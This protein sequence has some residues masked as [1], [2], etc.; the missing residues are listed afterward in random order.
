MALCKPALIH[1]AQACTVAKAQKP[2]FIKRFQ[3]V[4]AHWQYIPNAVEVN[5]FP[6]QVQNLNNDVKVLENHRKVAQARKGK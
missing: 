5:S 6:R 1:A 2:F 3:F 4:K